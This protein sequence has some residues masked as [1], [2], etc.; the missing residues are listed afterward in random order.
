M[1]I[2]INPPFGIGDKGYGVKQRQVV[3]N[4]PC[5]DCSTGCYCGTCKGS[6]TI[7][8]KSQKW[9]VDEEPLEVFAIRAT[10]S[11]H[12]IIYKYKGRIKGEVAHRS[13]STLFATMEEAIA[14]CDK[15]NKSIFA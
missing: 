11:K 9:F 5:Q 2:K 1:E 4:M 3:V 10:I 7:Q 6:G 8:V 15:R 13:D 14:D 12:Q